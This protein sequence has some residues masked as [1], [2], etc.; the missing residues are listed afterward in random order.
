MPRL[1]DYWSNRLA[2]LMVL[3]NNS[4]MQPNKLKKRRHSFR[5]TTITNTR[6]Q[7]SGDL[8][9]M[10]QILSMHLRMSFMKSMTHLI[11]LVLNCRPLMRQ[12]LVL[13][14][15]RRKKKLWPLLPNKNGRRKWRDRKPQKR[16]ESKMRQPLSLRPHK[17]PRWK[18]E[19]LPRRPPWKRK[20][21]LQIEWIISP[22]WVR[23]P[24]LNSWLKW[25]IRRFIWDFPSWK[26]T[27]LKQ[28]KKRPKHSGRNLMKREDKM[29]TICSS[30]K[31]QW[32]RPGL[33]WMVCSKGSLTCSAR[34]ILCK[35][36][37]KQFRI[38]RKLM[39]SINSWKK[40][41]KKLMI[42]MLYKMQWI[43][44]WTIFKLNKTQS[45]KKLTLVI[46][47]TKRTLELSITL[48]SL[49]KSRDKTN[50]NLEF[51]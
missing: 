18:P 11:F 31:I 14:K 48:E 33:K 5:R 3:L 28:L 35:H 16:R 29:M 21:D 23:K 38:W 20:G 10:K 40:S 25:E 2:M 50:R 44:R 32:T 26:M 17:K 7:S 12:K 4:E 41:K 36:N 49:K 19:D 43:Q 1:P 45:N 13:R 6:I 22:T 46:S 37:F 51:R 34:W 39:V 9:V 47:R 15:R 24:K 8:K 30:S 27:L 42:V